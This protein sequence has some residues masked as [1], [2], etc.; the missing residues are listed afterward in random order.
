MLTRMSG[1]VGGMAPGQE[2]LALPSSD[3]AQSTEAVS[4]ELIA[5]MQAE[6]EALGA[7][8]DFGSVTDNMLRQLLAKDIM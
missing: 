8:E 4:D 7:K 5:K 1:E 2:G 6:F 3:T